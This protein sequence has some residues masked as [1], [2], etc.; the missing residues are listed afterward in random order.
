LNPIKSCCCFI[1]QESTLTALG[2][3]SSLI[4]LSI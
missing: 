3:D 1:E 4:D 2:T